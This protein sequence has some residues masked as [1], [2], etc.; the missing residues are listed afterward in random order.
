MVSTY[1]TKPRRGDSGAD[2]GAGTEAAD[3]GW[4][5]AAGVAGAALAEARPSAVFVWYGTPWRGLIFPPPG[6]GP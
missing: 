1:T 3:G 2:T 6:G 4:A 5:V